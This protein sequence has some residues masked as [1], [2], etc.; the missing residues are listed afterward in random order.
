MTWEV[1][2]WDVVTEWVARSESQDAM[3][4]ILMWHHRLRSGGPDSGDDNMGDDVWGHV[5][6]GGV[7]VTYVVVAWPERQLLIDSVLDAG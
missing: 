7:L 2:G 4:D 6:P 5:A 3:F 1:E